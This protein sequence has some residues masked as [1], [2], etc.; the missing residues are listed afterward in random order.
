MVSVDFG[1]SPAINFLLLRVPPSIINHATIP[2]ASSI[3]VTEVPSTES[4]D[5]SSSSTLSGT[6]VTNNP[7]YLHHTDNT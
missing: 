2:H 5:L 4:T 1:V 3:P 6:E 7:Y